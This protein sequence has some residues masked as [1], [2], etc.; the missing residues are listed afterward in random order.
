L[1]INTL[2][3][4]EPN[5]N[6]ERV[7]EELKQAHENDRPLI[8]EYR[9]TSKDSRIVWLKDEAMIV[10][11]KNENPLYRQ[12]VM[13]DITD[14]K[15]AEEALR[16]SEERLRVKLDYILSPENEIEDVALIDLVSLEDLQQI[17]DAFA[18]A[19]DV[20][21]IISD[22]DGNPITKPSNFCGVCEIIRSTKKGNRNCIKS[23]KSVGEKAKALMKP[24]Y[25][26]CQSCGF[27]DASAPIIVGGKHIANWLIGQSNVM[28]V[29]RNR[30]E[31]YANEIGADTKKILDAFET[32]SEMSLEKFEQVLDLL[33]YF[34]KVLSTQGFN[35][36]KLARNIV[37]LKQA[38]EE[39][40]KA[41][42]ELEA[43]VKERTAELQAVNRELEAFAYS[44]SHDLRAPLRGID[45]FS[46]VLLE[47]YSN[48]LDDQGQHY[49]QRVRTAT[50]NMGQLI[51]DLLKL[52]HI[53]RQ[54]INKET[55]NIE[56][57]AR[58]VY[59]TLEH[60][61]KNRNV[62]LTVHQCPTVLAD[63]RLVEI[64]FT[65]LF[66]NAL[67][68]TLKR[69]TAE[70][71]VGCETKD[72][73]TIF[74]IKDNGAGFD[75]K[76]TDKLFTPFQR[77]HRKEDFEGTGIGLAIVQRIINRHGGEIWV[78]SEPGLGT[79]FYFTLVKLFGVTP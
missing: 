52:S 30:I 29:D 12:G 23:D 47:D 14:R 66:S 42:D 50:Q 37:E 64:V 73:Q 65:N 46:H 59:K 19:N 53:G 3:G 76:Y 6:C 62:N 35:N 24:A 13:F 26:K 28:G 75:M 38:D 20:A 36:F 44:I 22:V 51:D 17:Q 45:G 34:A 40:Q 15:Q 41:H 77:L 58:E 79:T 4:P 54:S 32:M 8:F 39:L 67:K 60:E 56:T 70:I 69:D 72:E 2:A 48:V 11:D 25:E 71:E 61:R 18:A 16:E 43:R 5:L 68:F 55:I 21:S 31:T 74:F 10:K 49:L 7:L 1:N 78:E 9:M 33:W 63:P 57:V 27:V